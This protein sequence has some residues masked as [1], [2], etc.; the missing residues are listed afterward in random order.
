MIFILSYKKQGYGGVIMSDYLFHRLQE[1]FSDSNPTYVPENIRAI[2]VGMKSVYMIL[3]PME[4]KAYKLDQ[5]KVQGDIASTNRGIINNAIY[6]RT[7]EK[8]KLPVIEEI[9]FDAQYTVKNNGEWINLKRFDDDLS[10]GGCRLRAYGF[11]YNVDDCMQNMASVK[12]KADTMV[13]D[14]ANF[15]GNIFLK[16]NKQ[17]YK[18][19]K[20]MYPQYKYFVKVD[21]YFE[22]IEEAA[23][24]KD[25]YSKILT[26]A[27]LDEMQFENFIVCKKLYI[28]LLNDKDPDSDTKVISKY[29]GRLFRT[30]DG[31]NVISKAFL[32]I[33]YFKEAANISNNTMSMDSFKKLSKM[34][35]LYLPQ[36]SKLTK[37]KIEERLNE[38]IANQDGIILLSYRLDDVLSA[39]YEEAKNKNMYLASKIL[40]TIEVLFKDNIPKGKFTSKAGIQ[41]NGIENRVE[42]AKIFISLLARLTCYTYD[43][44][45]NRK[46]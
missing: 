37:E 44:V 5:Y 19:Y 31:A 6:S 20:S 36:D 13:K 28:L 18:E 33:D 2:I 30:G 46:K 29:M 17:W 38:Y 14:I 43:S 45:R 11:V 41:G 40:A 7:S 16:D 26:L 12:L 8:V 32:P 25:L 10:A 3:F 15:R 34:Y 4:I 9:Y 39:I 23:G 35:E 42:A 22:S 21:K 27:S 1:I 24:K